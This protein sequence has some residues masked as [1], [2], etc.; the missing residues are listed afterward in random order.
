MRVI[1]VEKISKFINK[2]SD[3]SNWLQAWLA[4]A[5]S[6]NWQCTQDIKDRYRSASFL[7]DDIVIFN[8]I[9]LA[10]ILLLLILF[11]LQ[12]YYCC[13]IIPLPLLLCDCCLGKEEC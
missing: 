5:R 8:V 9:S 6:A 7:E 3:G 11:F 13:T 4:E 12:G 10:G 2:H 1:G